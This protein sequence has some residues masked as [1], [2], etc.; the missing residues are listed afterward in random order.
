MVLFFLPHA[1][2]SAKSYSS[3]KRFLPK[4]LS[5][6]PMEL[7]GRFTRSSEPLL[8]NVHDCVADL[9]EKH[10]E[11]L[12]GEYALF[13]HSMG[14]VLVTELV[15]QARE[16]GLALPC[17]VFLSGKNPPDEDV[18]C[19]E[20]VETASDEEIVSYFTKNSLST[21]APVPDEELMRTLNRILC[22]D[23]RMAER[24]KAT[25]EDVKFGC[26]IT[27][28]YGKDDPLM[29][30]VD[31]SSWSRFTDGSC[32][33]YPFDGGHFYYQQHKEEVCGIIKEKLHI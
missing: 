9:I 28:I 5:V 3:F 17:H 21:A 26:D 27:V 11:L 25:P 8:D 4:E 20:N 12:R 29:Q 15:K 10:S 32:K 13:G 7:S 1:G 33:V 16:K 6:V 18:H 2:G 14:T 23:V 31:M 19:F 22:T 24:Y 30:S